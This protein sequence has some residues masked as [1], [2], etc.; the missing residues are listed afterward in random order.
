M[1]AAQLTQAAQWSVAAAAAANSTIFTD[2][3]EGRN[4]SKPYHV[5]RGLGFFIA[6]KTGSYKFTMIGDDMYQLQG[7]YHNVS[8]AWPL[9]CAVC[10]E[11]L[12]NARYIATGPSAS[13][14]TRTS[15]TQC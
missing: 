15:L 7:M 14:G 12:T 9:E 8:A 5:S 4:Y 6:P 13:P 10:H 2:R 3:F 1:S 11:P